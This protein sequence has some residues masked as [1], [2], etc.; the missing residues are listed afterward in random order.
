MQL[1][2]TLTASKICAFRKRLAYE[3]EIAFAALLCACGGGSPSQAGG[4]SGGSGGNGGGSTGIP[5]FAH[6]FILVEENHSYSDVIG[7]SNMPYLNSL[8]S[9]YGLATQYFA[10]AHPSL[11]NYF[12]LTAGAGTAITG[13]QGDNYPGPVTQDNLVRAL[14]SAGKSWRF[15]GE[16]LPQIGYTGP[17]T[18][19]Y[20]HRHNPFSYLSDVLNSPVQ[21]A[22]LVP[23]TQLSSDLSSGTLPAYAFIVPDLS[24]DAHDCPSGMPTCTDTQKLANADQWL[25]NNIDPLIKSS[26]FQNS[27]LIITFDE[28]DASDPANGGGHVATLII[29]PKAKAGYQSTTLYQH[30][31]TLR[32]T[33]KALGVPDLPGGA[34][35]APDM[36]EFFQ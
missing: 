6:V 32:L 23:F 15:Y 28:G 9:A 22:N 36:T 4:G 17:D 12:T 2:S 34:A 3:P 16:A 29:S 10:D 19:L 31:S 7:N 35:T 33:M 26:A 11:P 5:Q 8:G 14:T 13:T 25:K 24:N 1:R 30:E 20:V 18:G 21:A 27:L